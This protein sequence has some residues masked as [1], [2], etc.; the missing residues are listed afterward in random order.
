MLID[1]SFLLTNWIKILLI[2]L[3]FLGLLGTFAYLG[4]NLT[5]AV[6]N[7]IGYWNNTSPTSSVFSVGTFEVTNRSTAT[8]VAYCFAEVAGYS[9][10]G[11]YTGNGS[12][13][14]PFVYC[15]FK[16][17]FILFKNSSTAVDWK[18]FDTARNTYNVVGEELYPNLSN[19]GS[20]ATDMDILSNGFKIRQSAV[21]INQNTDTYIYMAF[22]E[23]PFKYAKAR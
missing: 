15:G 11:S 23:N 14:G 13:D 2:I 3:I 5:S 12:T 18:I 16:P 4:L 9:K 22:A 19:A 21:A 20:T 6:S 17:R 7:D 1:L 8:Y 10:F